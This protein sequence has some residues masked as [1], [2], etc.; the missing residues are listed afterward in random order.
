MADKYIIHGATFNGDGT[1][2]AAAASNGGVGAWNN[3]NVLE[4]TAPAFGTLAAGDVV[5]IRSKDA[6]GAD[7]TRTLTASVS[8]GSAAATAASFITWVLD[9]GATWPGIDG[10]FTYTTASN[11]VSTILANNRIVAKRRGAIAFVN[12]SAAPAAGWQLVSVSGELIG[13]RLDRSAQTGTGEAIIATL[14]DNS[15]IERPIVKQGRLGSTPTT[16]T[17]GLFN[18]IS[19]TKRAEV[20]DPDIELMSGAGAGVAVFRSTST[21]RINVIGGRIYGA[22]A[23]SGQAVFSGDGSFRSIGLQFPRQMDVVTPTQI[24]G[25]NEVEAIACDEVLGGHIGRDWGFATSRTDAN[26]PTRQAWLP[27]SANTPWSW[28]VYPKNASNTA[29]MHLVMSKMFTGAA[30]AKT[31]TLDLLIADSMT[32]DKSSLWITVEYTDDATGEPRHLSTRD[33]SAPPLDASTATWSATVWGAVTFNRRKLAAVTPGP[34]RQD[35]LITVTLWG[36][37]AGGSTDDIYFVDP[38]F[39][40]N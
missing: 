33:W 11:F 27:D 7:I 34:I 5:Y 26:P 2:S 39:G 29:P 4:G 37:V 19:G 36:T 8:M 14:N 13:P 3:I 20:V 17:R 6:A 23:T 30:A 9:D 16:S 22:G 32:S 18:Y 31:I 25:I 10:T 15:L 1:S 35:S 21:R 24:G 40:V 38:D 12:T 28:R